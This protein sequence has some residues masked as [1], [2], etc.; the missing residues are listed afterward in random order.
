MAKII[1]ADFRS[2]GLPQTG[3]TPSIIIWEV[4]AG[5]AADV[6]VISGDPMIEIGNGFYKY[7]FTGF[8]P[9]KDYI[10]QADGGPS[11]S[12]AERYASGACCAPEPE[13]VADGVWEADS[14]L[15]TDISEMGGRHNATFNNVGQLL[16]DVADV[17]ALVDLVRKYQTN[18]TRISTTAKTLT[19]FDDDGLTPLRVFDLK[20]S[21]GTPSTS[22]VCERDPQ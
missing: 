13:E 19:V 3:L 7:T 9:R 12:D 10:Y 21:T 1:T 14:S 5:A 15:Y 2:G 6:L 17:E 8:D 11:L 22:E 18:R 4:V 20:D 16:L